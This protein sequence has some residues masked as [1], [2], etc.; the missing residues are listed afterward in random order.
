MNLILN[1]IHKSFATC[2]L[3]W[4]LDIERASDGIAIYGL[5]KLQYITVILIYPFQNGSDPQYANTLT[6]YTT[7]HITL[8]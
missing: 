8:K 1:F 5:S 4:L 7:E 2:S 6:W 3:E